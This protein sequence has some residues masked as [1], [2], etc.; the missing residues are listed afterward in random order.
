MDY[1]VECD[2]F[3]N[4]KWEHGKINLFSMFVR[5]DCGVSLMYEDVDISNFRIKLG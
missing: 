2:V 4:N 5:L 1:D 3:M